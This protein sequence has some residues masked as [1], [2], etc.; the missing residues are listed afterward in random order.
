M[1]QNP[2][3]GPR[4]VPYQGSYTPKDVLPNGRPAF[5]VTAPFGSTDPL[6]PTPHTGMDIGNFNCGDA[7]LAVADGRFYA[8]QDSSGALGARLRLATGWTVDVWHVAG[9]TVAHGTR[10]S[11]GQQ[12]AR[13]GSTGFS[14]GCHGHVEAIDPR[15][16]RVDIWPLLFQNRP[17]EYRRLNGPGINMRNGGPWGKVYAYSTNL[18]ILRASDGVK[19]APLDQAMRRGDAKRDSDGNWWVQLFLNGAYRWVFAA[20]TSKV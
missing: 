20:Y 19:L 6:H 16:K 11:A 4:I 7:V 14:T 10:V 2:V 1:F 12:I 17:K 8:M 9:F 15:G 18:G 13:I 5:R 3:L